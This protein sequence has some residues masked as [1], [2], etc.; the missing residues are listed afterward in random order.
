MKFFGANSMGP[1]SSC[2]FLVPPRVEATRF[3]L[4]FSAKKPCSS[5]VRPWLRKAGVSIRNGFLLINF[6]EP[7]PPGRR[8]GL[9]KPQQRVVLFGALFVQHAVLRKEVPPTAGGGQSDHQMEYPPPDS[10]WA[11][12]GTGSPL[13]MTA[14]SDSWSAANRPV[15][16]PTV[17]GIAWDPFHGEA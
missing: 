15:T 10:R 3:R 2:S 12:L 7:R 5:C 13:L 8:S 9:H 1:E 16:P 6:V 14:G 11:V 4:P 17:R